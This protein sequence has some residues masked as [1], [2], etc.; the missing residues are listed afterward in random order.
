M[1]AGFDRAGLPIGLHL[2]G[3]PLDEAGILN[4]AHRFQRET[5]WHMRLPGAF[6]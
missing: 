3:R 6:T 1:P 2:V 5:D 4:A